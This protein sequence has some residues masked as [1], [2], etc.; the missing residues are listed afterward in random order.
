M[1]AD[2]FTKPLQGNLFKIMRDVLMGH[3]SIDYLMSNFTKVSSASKERVVGKNNDD[4]I[5]TSASKI[6]SY[7][8]VC[9]KP[10]NMKAI[11][12]TN[13]ILEKIIESE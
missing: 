10:P 6:L 9:A 13:V 11:K 4:K 3:K 7:A 5:M 2:F 1:L 12:R 8:S